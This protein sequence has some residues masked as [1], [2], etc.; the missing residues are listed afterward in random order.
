MYLENIKQIITVNIAIMSFCQGGGGENSH[1]R[2]LHPVE[3]EHGF[4]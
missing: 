3:A 1:T 4:N 2:M